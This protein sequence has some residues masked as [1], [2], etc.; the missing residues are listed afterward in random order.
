MKKGLVFVAI[1]AFIVFVFCLADTISTVFKLKS[2]SDQFG[3]GL[4]LPN[5]FTTSNR[6]YDT[7]SFR[8]YTDYAEYI[9]PDSS[10]TAFQN[11]YAYKTVTEADI[12][13]LMEFFEDYNGWIKLREGYEDWY[14][15]DAEA[16]VNHGDCF[17]LM[18]DDPGNSVYG[19]FHDYDIYYFDVQKNTLYYFHNN[20]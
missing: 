20:S 4:L 17:I 2:P 12:P 3:H 6:H 5:G 15:F 11:H 8:D 13:E 14:T 7:E 19:K 1:F 10:A 9:Y 18:I 16:Q